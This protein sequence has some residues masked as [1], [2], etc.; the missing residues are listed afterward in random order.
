MH[1]VHG[2]LRKAPYIKQ[3]VG[4]DGQSTLF[5]VELSEVTKDRQTGD[6]SYANYSAALFAKSPAQINHYTNQL[7]EGNFIVVNC[8]KL[9]VDVQDSNGKQYIKLQM[10][11]A[12]LEG[13]KY[14]DNQ[15]QAP[16]Q[17]FQQAPPQQAPQQQFAPQFAPQ[18]PPQAPQMIAPINP[19]QM[20]QAPTLAQQAAQHPQAQPCDDDIPFNQP[21]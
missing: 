17:G 7:V 3:G 12:R 20:Q 5:I 19:Q 21:R 2:E 16:Q 11:N 8:E 13:T 9:R 15:Q 6:K 10:E 4:A 1:I 14:I 18:W